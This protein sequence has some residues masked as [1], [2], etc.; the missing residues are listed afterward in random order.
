MPDKK[1]RWLVTCSCGWEREASSAWAATAS[2][3]LHAQLSLKSDT[4][5][6]IRIEEPEPPSGIQLPLV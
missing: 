5:H 1:S 4:E 2:F 6:I 3:R